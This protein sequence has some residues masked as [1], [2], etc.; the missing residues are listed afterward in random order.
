[1]LK[2]IWYEMFSLSGMEVVL[3]IYEWIQESTFSILRN[4]NNI[5]INDPK[6]LK[7]MLQLYG[8]NKITVYL[9]RDSIPLIRGLSG[10]HCNKEITV[11]PF[12]QM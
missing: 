3:S 4:A 11:S 8:I 2:V 12:L 10:R 7:D 5:L 9:N 6:F 1:M